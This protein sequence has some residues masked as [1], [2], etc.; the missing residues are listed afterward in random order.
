MGR[1][2]MQEQID[3][4]MWDD[5]DGDCFMCGGS[6]ELDDECECSEFEDVCCCAQPVPRACPECR[7]QARLARAR[8]AGD[9]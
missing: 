3:D 2:E 7:H 1:K 8:A 9:D 6:G 4:H 5:G